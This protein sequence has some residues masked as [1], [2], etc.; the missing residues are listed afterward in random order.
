MFPTDVEVNY[1]RQELE[2]TAENF[3]LVRDARS[4][5]TLWQ[6]IRA[7]LSARP[8]SFAT[9]SENGAPCPEMIA[10]SR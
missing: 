4:V 1:R 6:Q 5:P 3:R 10:T 9:R 8:V 7:R 2:R